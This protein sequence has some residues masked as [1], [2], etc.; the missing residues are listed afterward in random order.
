VTWIEY[1]W[2]WPLSSKAYAIPAIIMEKNRVITQ[3]ITALPFVIIVRTWS[4]L[5]ITIVLSNAIP[6]VV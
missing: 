3:N 1:S 5:Q 4:G 2:P 6:I